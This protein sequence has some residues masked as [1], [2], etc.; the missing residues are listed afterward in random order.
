VLLHLSYSKDSRQAKRS[1]LGSTVEAKLTFFTLSAD[2]R[3]GGIY[4]GIMSVLWL[5]VGLKGPTCLAGRPPRFA[6][7]P[8]FLAAP[9]LGIGYPMH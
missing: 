1:N 7:R 4:T 2:W 5:K 3:T 9:T 6:K 8:S